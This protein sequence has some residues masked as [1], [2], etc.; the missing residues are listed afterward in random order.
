MSV[1][2]GKCGICGTPKIEFTKHHVVEY[3]D[4]QGRT[5][6]ID[7]CKKCHDQQEKYR[8]YLKN[9]CG[10]DIVRKDPSFVFKSFYV[11]ED[12]ELLENDYGQF[13][14]FDK[15]NKNSIILR[16]NDLG[17]LSEML[18]TLM[19]ELAGDEESE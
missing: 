1:N 5:P 2:V 3:E 11:G 12:W 16:E 8:N 13:K 15:I 19:N 7:I 4:I 10:I 9:F 6:K 18:D 17:E 14:I